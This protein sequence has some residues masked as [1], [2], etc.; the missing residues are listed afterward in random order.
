MT[1]ENLELIADLAVKE[2]KGNLDERERAELINWRQQHPEQ[3]SQIYA[4]LLSDRLREEL[5]LLATADKGIRER[6]SKA[7]VLVTDSQLLIRNTRNLKT[8]WFRYAASIIVVL[9]ACAYL[10]FQQHRQQ[11]MANHNKHF[12]ADIQ[13]G[14][15]G[16]ILTLS[17]GSQMVLDSLGNGLIATQSSTQVLLQN[18]QLIYN[19]KGSAG[20]N[21]EYNTMS[22]PRGRQF[23]L[24]LP[25]GTLVRL[26]AASSLRYPT[27]FAGNERRVEVT[28]EAY[29]EVAK[30]KDRPFW[31]K[32]NDQAEVEVLGTSFNVNAY[33]NED[34]IQTT[35]IEGKVRVKSGQRAAGQMIAGGMEAFLH[36]GEQAQIPTVDVSSGHSTGFH[37][38]IQIVQNVSINK[39]LAWRRGVFNFQDAGLQEVAKQLERWYDIEVVFEKGIPAIRFMGEISRS[40]KL[41]GVLK[42]LEDMGIR[43]RMEA[44]KR[45]VILP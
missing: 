38:P 5:A 11:P 4:L 9:G 30:D 32:I 7:S 42:G 28:G 33:Q 12:P 26:N 22:T 34:S 24:R 36:P 45:L 1:F 3:A 35:L 13:P 40:V 43:F 21:M 18:S 44:G 6:M 8:M 2:L 39:V 37:Q 16:A 25:D 10:F 41:S 20:K 17:D 14:R 29:F 15:D 31:V 19:S 23:N 27:A